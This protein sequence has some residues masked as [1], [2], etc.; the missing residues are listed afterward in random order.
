MVDA[1]VVEVRNVLG[2]QKDAGGSHASIGFQPVAGNPF[3]LAFTPEVLT[4]LFS[5][6]VNA[7]GQWP[8]P[9]MRDRP[10]CAIDPKWIEVGQAGSDSFALSI[11]LDHGGWIH[12]YQ[13]RQSL[14]RLIDLLNGLVNP[15]TPPTSG[16][17]H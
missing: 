2:F 10:I 13:S 4:A 1:P 5:A 14:V 12:F 8:M 7:L 6:V 16:T 9:R 17:P 15:S 11:Q 3:G